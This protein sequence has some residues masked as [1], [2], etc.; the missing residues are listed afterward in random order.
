MNQTGAPA[1]A[2][3][4]LLLRLTTIQLQSVSSKL[5]DSRK[6]AENLTGC[7]TSRLSSRLTAGSQQAAHLRQA[8]A[9]DNGEAQALE[10]V[11][12]VDSQGAAAADHALDDGQRRAHLL[13]D[14]Q[15]R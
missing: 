9:V 8:P 14:Q 1:D 2:L 6:A 12:Q 5:P 7:R 10:E 3:A 11:V 4:Q 13:E 15:L